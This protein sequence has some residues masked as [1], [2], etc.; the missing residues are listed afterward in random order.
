MKKIFWLLVLLAALLLSAAPVLAD[1]EFYVIAGGGGV[2]T[3]ITSLPYPITTPGFY[4][5]TGNLSYSGSSNGITVSSDDVTIDLMGFRLSGPGILSGSFGIYVQANHKNV[6][7]RNG[8]L[9]N[10]NKA[11]YADPGGTN[12]GHRVINIRAEANYG[13]IELYGSGHLTKGCTAL[14]NTNNYGIMCDTEAT[15]SNNVVINSSVGIYCNSGSVIGNNVICN[16]GQT[17][18]QLGNN[19]GSSTLMDQNNVNGTGTHYMV[20]GSGNLLWAGKNTD[21]PWGSNAGHP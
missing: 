4:Y 20:I 10:W 19:M 15:I 17:G 9:R 13:G 12:Y 1:G 16:S 7:I 3:K 18:I 11:I 6:E 21:N 2:G 14:N 5:L 8:V